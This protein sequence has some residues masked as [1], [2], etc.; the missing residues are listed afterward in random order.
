M[1]LSAAEIEEYYGRF[2]VITEGFER[3]ALRVAQTGRLPARA[4]TR[5]E[6]T[7]RQP[8]R[9]RPDE[10]RRQLDFVGLAVHGRCGEIDNS[11]TPKEMLP[12]PLPEGNS[13]LGRRGL[14]F[15]PGTWDG[16]DLFCPADGTHIFV[17][18][19]VRD[20]LIAAKARNLHFQP[21]TEVERLWD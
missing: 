1:P 8:A 9:F 12:P 11:L 17:T 15:K 18:R 10:G 21:L 6:R 16:S 2:F 14:L 5:G 13:V 3:G 20:A 4:L 7:R 19:A